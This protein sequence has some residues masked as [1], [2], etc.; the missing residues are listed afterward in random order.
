MGDGQTDFGAR[1]PSPPAPMSFLIP[2]S[3]FLRIHTLVFFKTNEQQQQPNGQQHTHPTT[4]QPPGTGGSEHSAHGTPHNR[5]TTQAQYVLQGV[6]GEDHRFTLQGTQE[7]HAVYS[8]GNYF[9]A[10]FPR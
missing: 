3:S 7:K 4:P 6:G 9:E 5:L 1:P 2:I 8:S 10:A